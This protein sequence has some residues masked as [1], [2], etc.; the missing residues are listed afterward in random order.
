MTSE[1]ALFELYKQIKTHRRTSKKIIENKQQ[2][3]RICKDLEV[4]EILKSLIVYD[5]REIDSHKFMELYATTSDDDNINK[6]K[7]WLENE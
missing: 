6:I 4:L 7:E 3:E 2:Y 1:E 5:E